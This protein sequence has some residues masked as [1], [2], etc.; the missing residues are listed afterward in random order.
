MLTF[1]SGQPSCRTVVT[2]AGTQTTP[3]P[4]VPEC[5]GAQGAL[6]PSGSVWSV[7]PNEHQYQRVHVYATTANGVVDLGPGTNSTMTVCG[8]S[9]FW[10]RD[11][12]GQGGKADLMRWDGSTLT[13][14]YESNAGSAFLGVPLCADD[15]L[16]I[17][18]SAD[19]GDQQVSARL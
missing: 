8:D 15:V 4:G 2:V 3:F 14:A 10:S 7:V 5:K 17:Y 13:I 9:V 11:A 1:D 12:Q 19:G 16:S 18:S 6:L